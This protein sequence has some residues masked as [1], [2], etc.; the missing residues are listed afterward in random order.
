MQDP[1]FERST[2]DFSANDRD[3]ERAEVVSGL[4]DVREVVSRNEPSDPVQY[5]FERESW[6]EKLSV[7]EAMLGRERLGPVYDQLL[8]HM[9][10]VLFAEA[11]DLATVDREARCKFLGILVEQ[12]ALEPTND[13]GYDALVQVLAAGSSDEALWQSIC[14]TLSLIHI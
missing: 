4:S 14:D 11:E 10:D 3:L 6:P 7:L 12:F 2:E 1:L 8:D 5:I 13:L 9:A